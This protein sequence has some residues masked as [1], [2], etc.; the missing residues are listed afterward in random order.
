ML[1]ILPGKSKECNLNFLL[2]CWTCRTSTM[3]QVSTSTSPNQNEQWGQR[4]AAWEKTTLSWS[5]SGIR[6]CYMYVYRMDMIDCIILN[7]FWD[8][9]CI[10]KVFRPARPRNLRKWWDTQKQKQTSS[11]HM[12]EPT[13]VS[14]QI[15]Y[16]FSLHYRFSSH[17]FFSHLKYHSPTKTYPFTVHLF[18]ATSGMS[19]WG[20]R[21]ARVFGKNLP[22]AMKWSDRWINW[23][24]FSMIFFLLRKGIEGLE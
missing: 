13:T 16:D 21:N 3:K 6:I 17:F 8:I 1:L 7:V 4:Q 23:E 14:N 10:L 18:A 9:W 22:E 2:W 15:Y 20:I 5:N 24:D 12:K 19:S 11:Q